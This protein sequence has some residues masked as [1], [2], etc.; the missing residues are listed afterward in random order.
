MTALR[1]RTLLSWALLNR[2][3]H[4]RTS[5]LVAPG[6]LRVDFTPSSVAEDNFVLGE[7]QFK[8][9]GSDE[10]DKL[11]GSILIFASAP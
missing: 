4:S 3:V 6:S 2:G 9:V 1:S 8:Y 10:F 11:K 7:N 5:Y